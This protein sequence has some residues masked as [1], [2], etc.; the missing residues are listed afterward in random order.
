MSVPVLNA[1]RGCARNRQLA[2]PFNLRRLYRS[3]RGV[4]GY[5]PARNNDSGLK[6]SR[7]EAPVQVDHGLERLVTAYREHGHKAAKIDPLS[8]GVIEMIPEIQVLTEALQGHDLFCTK[9]K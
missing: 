1:M 2:W 9:G 6:V 5:K 3:E 7:E 8:Q 4:Y